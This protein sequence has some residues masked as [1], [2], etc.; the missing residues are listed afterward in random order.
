M[1]RPTGD[2][3]KP[4]KLHLPIEFIARKRGYRSF[5]VRTLCYLPNA[6]LL[7]PPSLSL[8]RSLALSLVSALN[9]EQEESNTFKR[10]PSLPLQNFRAAQ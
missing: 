7:S 3:T 9:A 1:Q 5:S 4:I 6:W 10:Q 8:T 2:R